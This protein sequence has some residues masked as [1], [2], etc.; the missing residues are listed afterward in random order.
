VA[1]FRPATAK[2]PSNVVWK[3][4]LVKIPAALSS[5]NLNLSNTLDGVKIWVPAICGPGTMTISNFTNVSVAAPIFGHSGWSTS[6]RAG[7]TRID[8]HS[9]VKTFAVVETLAFGNESEL[10]LQFIGADGK[11]LKSEH[12]GGWIGTT[13]PKRGAIRRHTVE[14]LDTN[15]QTAALEI[16]LNRPLDFE[17]MIDP[18]E[19]KTK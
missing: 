6:E 3:L 19:I 8:R 18:R 2:F 1:L 11:V 16:K 13:D 10:V 9:S 7:N 4:P 15:A 17:F 14:L 12:R 5:T